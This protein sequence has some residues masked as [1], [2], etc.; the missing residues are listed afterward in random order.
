MATYHVTALEMPIYFNREGDHDHNGLIFALTGNVPI[1]KF[2]RAIGAHGWGDAKAL[3]AAAQARAAEIEVDL[4]TT[5]QQARQPHP[6]VRPLVL[7]AP[8]GEHLEVELKNEIRHRHVGLH[9]VGDGY[10]VITADGSQVGKNPSSLT[11]PNG[12][13]TYSWRC[14]HEGVF[15]FHD[16]GNYSGGEDGT[17]VHGLFGAL[18]VEPA[19]AIWRD[20]VTGRRSEDA[21]GAFQE[22]DGLYMDILPPGQAQAQPDPVSETTLEDHVWPAPEAY[23]VFDQKAHREFVVVFHDEPEFQPPHGEPPANPCGL[24]GHAGAGPGE[25]G[26]HG[27]MDGHAPMLPIMPISYRAEPLINREHTLWRLL[28]DGHVLA[29]PVLNE[30]QHHS[31]WMFGD[32]ATPILKAYIGDPVRIRLLHAGVLETHVFH[33]H[34]YEWHAVPGDKSSP[35]IDAISISP[36]TGHTIEP[37]WGAG[38][39]QQAAGDTIWHCHLYPHFHEGM[40]GIFR[41]FETR[42]DGPDGGEDLTSI[43][44]AYAGRKIGRYPDG[45]PIQRLLPLPDRPAP[46]K[47][48]PARP[49]YPLYIPGEVRQKSPVPPW[50]LATAM[51]GDFDYRPVPTDLECQAFNA[52]PVPGEMFTRN[53]TAHQQDQEWK[54]NA[55]FEAN[56]AKVVEHDVA[57][58]RRRIDYNSHG[59]YD[60]DGHLYFLDRE[61]DPESRPGAK[62]PL[63]FRA[64]HGQILNLT[65]ANRLP[66][67]IAGTAYDPP[68]PPCPALPWEGEC[69]M[70]VHMVKFDPVCGD[71]GSVGWNYISAP[72][73]G[74]RFV[75]RWWADQEFGTIFFHDH[76]FANYR[77][78]HGLFGALIVEPIGATF[79]DAFSDGEIVSGLQARIQLPAGNPEPGRFRE[80]CI[81]IGDFIP[82]FDRFGVALNPPDHPGGHG[83]QGVM[84][85]N[86]RSEPLRERPG[87]PAYWFSSRRH[88]DPATTRFLTFAGDPLRLRVMQGSHEE[89]H[90]FQVHGM[91]WRRFRDNAGSSL[92]N[93][94]TFGIAE[95]FTFDIADPVGPGD[96]LYKLSSA[97]DIWL[98]CWGL[99]RAFP[100]GAA[101]EG[102][103]TLVE[104]AADDKGAK[105][106][107]SYQAAAGAATAPAPGYPEGAIVRRFR[108]VAEPQRLTYRN[109]ELVDPFGLVYRLV[110]FTG[111][112]EAEQ[113]VAGPWVPEPLILRCREGEWVEVTLSNNLPAVLRPEPFAPEVPVEGRNAFRPRRPVSNHV[114]M[115]ADMLLYDVNLHDGANVGM[116]PEQ[117]AAPGA[118]CVYR[119]HAALPEGAD[120]GEEL[121]PVLLQ[122]MA[123]VRNHRHHGLIG[124]LIV[125]PRDATPYAVGVGEATAK[126][127]AANA[128][129]GARA[130]V[131][132]GGTPGS[133]A[134]QYEEAVLL[135]QDGLRLYLNGNPHFPIPDAPPAAGEEGVDAE[136]QGQKGFNYRAEPVGPNTD[137][138]GK[139]APS[140]NW[141][142][143]PKPATPVF[144]VPQGRAVRLHLVGACDKPRNHSV[145]VHGVTWPEYRFLQAAG[146]SPR[147]ASESAITSG[148]AR[149]FDF[150]AEHPGDHA[151]RSGVL[152]WTVS[153]GLWGILRVTKLPG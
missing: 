17:N 108:V 117:T 130:T 89:Q 77:Q 93:Q 40:W 18:V 129:H 37:V 104:N 122:D 97:D 137:M 1:L 79:L 5:A 75:Y 58:V 145:T 115:H 116:N 45:T 47:P 10:A 83:D 34:L 31:S 38:D 125:E 112:G 153:Q 49:G 22:L 142:A 107:G 25:G 19:G 95:A 68:F 138:N 52:E 143:N 113:L 152:K 15:P 106:C 91:R 41:T 61:G 30:E 147:V 2:I 148:T 133:G 131:V 21:N 127:A 126:N 50:P 28:N 141:L 80:F 72:R 65:L 82:M 132:I 92:R 105:G 7:R 11:P 53:P 76:L 139:P 73:L 6:L 136:D 78:K 8:K 128:W 32:P 135:L 29:R 100:A 90:S 56:G 46:P 124:A 13:R 96:Y 114:S 54:T 111:P 69:S 9:L 144:V 26:G 14:D 151:Y 24:A 59:W 81:A 98:G 23:P 149:T 64:R 85:L 99:I 87:D 67:T 119:W 134:D 60:P 33:L 20:P 27:G 110:A 101:A 44:A 94:Q 88:P 42:Q 39:R 43:D 118:S 150:T 4:P 102:V 63:F 35:R 84:A 74:R 16:A 109:P 36:Q 123:D 3:Q 66:P 146:S 120:A 103:Y 48:T 51:P 70:H 71:G 121:G 55:A 57:V 62:E 86:Y 12:K 140:G